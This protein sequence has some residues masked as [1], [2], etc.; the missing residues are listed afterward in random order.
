MNNVQFDSLSTGVVGIIILMT[1]MARP[2]YSSRRPI[3]QSR[4]SDISPDDTSLCWTVQFRQ[5][6]PG[7]KYNGRKVGIDNVDEKYIHKGFWNCLLYE[8]CVTV[9]NSFNIALLRTHEKEYGQ[10]SKFYDYLKS[11]SL[12]SDTTSYYDTKHYD[13]LGNHE[14]HSSVHQRRMS[15]YHQT[16]LE[17]AN[18]LKLKLLGNV[19]Q[20]Y[21]HFV[22][23]YDKENGEISA[24][25]AK[26]SLQMYLISHADIRRNHNELFKSVSFQM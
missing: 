15:L 13:N 11:A 25:F 3:S 17:L 21:D 26:K 23:C 7:N 6:L 14:A 8:N 22:L 24:K 2:P 16:A 5:H 19:G 12:K 10:K 20:L 1:V 9:N 18:E 4:W